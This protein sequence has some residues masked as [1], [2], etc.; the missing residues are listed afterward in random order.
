MFPG[1]TPEQ[2]KQLEEETRERR[3]SDKNCDRTPF[4]AS[5]THSATRQLDNT[6][7]MMISG[8]TWKCH[9]EGQLTKT[10]VSEPPAGRFPKFLLPRAAGRPQKLKNTLSIPSPTL[11]RVVGGER[12]SGASRWNSNFPGLH[13]A[14]GTHPSKQLAARAPQKSSGTFN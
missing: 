1:K 10:R 8:S 13:M 3:K 7:C 4:V 12:I 6:R 5:V 9:V 14:A 11:V 2:P